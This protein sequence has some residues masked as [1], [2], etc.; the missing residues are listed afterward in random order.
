MVFEALYDQVVPGGLIIVD[1]YGAF[2][3]CRRATDEFLARRNVNVHIIYVE[4]S[5]R[6]FVKPWTM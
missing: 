6:Y 5:L 4:N 3:G 1:D 2:Q